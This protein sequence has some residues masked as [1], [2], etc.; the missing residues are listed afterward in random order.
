VILSESP[1]LVEIVRNRLLAAAR[2]MA[3]S[4]KRATY[5]P[6]IREALDFSNAIHD[7]TGN[8]VT[9]AEGIPALLGG[10]SATLHAALHRVDVETLRP[11]D[12]IVAND[13]YEAANTHLNDVSLIRPIFHD[14]ELAFYVQSKAHMLDIG[15]L[16]PGS[17]SPNATNL[18][19]EGL[20]IPPLKLWQGGILN[21][22]VLEVILANVRVPTQVRADLSAQEAACRAGE[23]W[24]HE[25]LDRYGRA[26]VDACTEAILNHGEALMRRRIDLIPDGVY[27]AEDYIDS[28]GVGDAPVKIAVRV[29]VTGDEIVVDLSGSD[30]QTA[31]SNGNIVFPAAVA[32][33]RLALRC[34]I[35]ADLPA[36]DG[37]NRPI[38]VIAQ[39]GTCVHPNLPAPCTVGVANGSHAILE[40][41]FKA[42]APVVPD[43]AV[44][45]Q[46][47]C[48]Q[49]LVLSGRD[50]RNG[51]LFINFV[52]SSAGGGGARATRDGLNGV[53]TLVDGDVRNVPA[54]IQEIRYP[55]RLERFE[56][57]EDSGGPGRTRGG[58]GIRTDF[59]I[60]AET[61][62]GGTTLNRYRIA[63]RGLFGG[64]DGRI[65][66]TVLNP[67][68]ASE[69]VCF[70]E[71]FE[72]HEGDLVSH[73][74]GGGGGYGPAWGRKPEQVRDDVQ[75]GYVSR[76]AA[77]G[78]Y[79]VALA[80]D[81]S[82]NA[83]ETERL[84]A[85]AV[86]QAAAVG[87]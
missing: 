41:I 9:Q 76:E 5:S 15:G 38:R 26:D 75:D 24:L 83:V 14:G 20:R 8:A 28:D 69:R 45:D 7:A 33:V 55:I 39:E 42:L 63:P 49:V 6:L 3:D 54:E 87:R 84:R 4:L 35:G 47:G 34:L 73:Q 17:W 11:G 79:K 59:R 36:N 18:Y 72:L 67:G 13:P 22:A 57:I 58:L 32:A 64:S 68:S 74:T 71:E 44:A 62:I 30:P 86:E 70:F 53:I 31:G 51:E 2:E 12:V 77:R 27:H 25:L 43:R 52:G 19:Q 50:P 78:S 21:E 37:C 29:E 85:S 65:N 1:I 82:V 16:E 40:G 56:L 60:L 66:R 23:R 10:M 46:F 81:Q 61:A 80:D 48:V